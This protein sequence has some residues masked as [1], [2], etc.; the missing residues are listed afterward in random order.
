[1]GLKKDVKTSRELSEL[2]ERE[3]GRDRLLAELVERDRERD[4]RD[5]ATNERLQQV[6]ARIDRMSVSYEA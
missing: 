1:V 6:F 5:A 3:A 4:R 2:L